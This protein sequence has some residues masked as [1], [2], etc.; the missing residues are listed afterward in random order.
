M[1]TQQEI[2]AFWQLKRLAVV[3]VSRNPRHY[4]NAVWREL[5][6]RRYDVVPVNP[7]ATEIDGRRAFARVQDI[8]P[9]VEGVVVLAPPSVTEQV[10]LDC[11]AAGIRSVWLRRGAG[12]GRGAVSPAVVE[13]ARSA[14]M[15]VIAGLC[16]FMFLPGTPA[17][18]QAHAF[19]KKMTGTYPKSVASQ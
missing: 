19:L 14:G 12:G 1:A 18:H 7:N 6:D 3:G 13:Q 17:F 9:P 11:L 5:R 2:D 10:V 4:T 15:I 8:D 16:P